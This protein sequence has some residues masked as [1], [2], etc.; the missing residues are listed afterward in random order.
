LPALAPGQPLRG[1]LEAMQAE[2]S[3]DARHKSRMVQLRL[4][5]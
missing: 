2:A 3:A 4:L 5:H 1:E